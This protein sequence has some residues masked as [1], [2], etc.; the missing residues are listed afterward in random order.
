MGVAKQRFCPSC[1][2]VMFTSCHS[3]TCFVSSSQTFSETTTPAQLQKFASPTSFLTKPLFQTLGLICFQI[4]SPTLAFCSGHTL[5][6]LN[7][8]MAL[9]AFFNL[10]SCLLCFP[11]L[12]HLGEKTHC[13]FHSHCPNNCCHIHHC[14]WQHDFCLSRHCC[15]HSHSCQFSFR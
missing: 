15:C 5:A 10:A 14:S 11:L 1:H 12:C 3:S 13:H 2:L 4:A 6:M 9:Q 8:T 7:R